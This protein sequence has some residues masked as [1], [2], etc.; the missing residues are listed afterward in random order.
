MAILRP[1]EI[2]EMP[3]KELAGKLVELKKEMMKLK[4]QTATGASKD[5][6]RIKAIRRTIARVYT[7]K[8]IV[9]GVKTKV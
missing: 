5:A 7:L 8:N 2:R 6:G 9:G 4:L 1:K 3:E